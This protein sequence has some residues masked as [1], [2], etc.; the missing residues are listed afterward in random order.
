[1]SDVKVGMRLHS[2]AEYC[3]PAEKVITVTEL[4]DKGFKYSILEAYSI[5]PRLGWIKN[6]DGHEL[7]SSNGEVVGYELANFPASE[8]QYEFDFQQ[9]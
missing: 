9:V 3:H 1:M 6:K 7:R 2:T 5:H 8:S 4:T